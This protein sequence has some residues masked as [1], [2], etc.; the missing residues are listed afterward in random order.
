VR[1]LSV[2]IYE[3]DSYQEKGTK[4]QAPRAALKRPTRPIVSVVLHSAREFRGIN[5]LKLRFGIRIK[6]DPHIG[7]LELAECLH[8]HLE[9]LGPL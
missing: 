3:C 6:A 1:D 5:C 4:I 2:A 7:L 8:M 9:L